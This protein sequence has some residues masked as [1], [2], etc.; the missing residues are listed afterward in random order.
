MNSSSLNRI[1]HVSGEADVS[2]RKAHHPELDG[3]FGWY[4]GK[5]LLPSHSGREVFVCK[6]QGV[7]E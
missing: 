2:Q 1:L 3:E 5:L 7:D 4:H 6:E